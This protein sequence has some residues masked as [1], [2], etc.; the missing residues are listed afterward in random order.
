M[1]SKAKIIG[2]SDYIKVKKK[3]TFYTT[4]QKYQIEENMFCKICN[5][6]M[7]TILY[8]SDKE[9]ELEIQEK[10][11]INGQWALEIDKEIN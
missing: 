2:N 10:K 8:V 3:E 7:V 5:R 6:K 11:Y 4:K 1:T 9:H